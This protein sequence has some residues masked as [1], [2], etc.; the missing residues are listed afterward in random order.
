MV[1][2]L[3]NTV[4]LTM[5]LVTSIVVAKNMAIT[6]DDL[7]VNRN[8]SIKELNSITDKIL[9]GLDKYG[10]VKVQSLQLNQVSQY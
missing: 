2:L 3:R 10:F 9:Q 7:P 5:L 4:L 6:F 1:K 8:V